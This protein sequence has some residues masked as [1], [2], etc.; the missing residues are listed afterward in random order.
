[1]SSD[2]VWAIVRGAM[3]RPGSDMVSD[4]SRP[5]NVFSLISGCFDA[6]G[7]PMRGW[8]TAPVQTLTHSRLAS[9]L[10]F[11]FFT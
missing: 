10:F 7:L 11:S 1:M 2:G 5:K 8:G 9:A 3:L 6:G 4:S